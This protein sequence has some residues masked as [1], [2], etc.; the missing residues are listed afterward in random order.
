VVAEL[1]QQKERDKIL[2]H[3]V[4][5]DVER[6][7]VLS[8]IPVSLRIPS[9]RNIESLQV[10]SPDREEVSVIECKVE[11]IWATFQIPKLETYDLVVVQLA[12]T[13]IP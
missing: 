2:L 10:L 8:D 6:T 3:L 11:G 9:E 5:Y 13:G 12:K 7:P 4:N 1:L